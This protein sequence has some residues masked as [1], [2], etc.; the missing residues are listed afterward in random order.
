MI[1][2]GNDGVSR[3]FVKLLAFEKPEKESPTFM[4]DNEHDVEWH[5]FFMNQFELMWVKAREV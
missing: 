4:L 5:E 2:E 3:V 1:I